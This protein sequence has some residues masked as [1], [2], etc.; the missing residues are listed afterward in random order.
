MRRYKEII[1]LG[2]YGAGNFGDD[3]MLRGLL[4][5]LLSL[6][7]QI[8]IN[9]V[10]YYD[11]PIPLFDLSRVQIVRV[12]SFVAKLVQLVPLFCKS[13]FAIFGGGTPFT[14]TEGDG[15]YKFFR[16]ARLLGCRFGYLGIGIGSMEN[17]V[18]RRRAGW[19][20]R[21]CDFAVFR[22][23]ESMSRARELLNQENNTYFSLGEDLSY[24]DIN[25]NH[26]FQKKVSVDIR[27]TR[28]LVVSWRQIVF[29][30]ADIC[31][32]E[33]MESF[34]LALCSLINQLNIVS[35]TLLPL[36]L[37][38]DMDVHRRLLSNILQKVSLD[39]L[40]ID[41]SVTLNARRS[42]IQNADM[43]IS[44]R[45][46]GVLMGKCLGVPTV[47]INYSPKVRYY[48]DSIDS[49]SFIEWE[50]LLNNQGS[51]TQ[52]AEVAFDETNFPVNLLPRISLARQSVQ[53]ALRIIG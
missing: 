30:E 41:Q 31:P 5:E 11:K 48:F 17:Q 51:L 20:L 53:A 18:R 42:V 6:D 44:V 26:V 37:S 24:L 4:A 16:L 49:K 35:V 32:E 40:S 7:S 29:A 46:H 12:E 8:R 52:A 50:D 23:P 3:M 14:D 15:S 10:S 19:L 34:A 45:L 13:S 28:N 47:G 2:Y 25:T 9:V 33:L 39:D 36:D 1:L 38:K 43:Y 21:E 27:N 22:D